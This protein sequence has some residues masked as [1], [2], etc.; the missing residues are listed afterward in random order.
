MRVQK[1]SSEM[2]QSAM[3][4]IS[5]DA[6]L[7]F[8]CDAM[9]RR[10]PLSTVRMGDGERMLIDYY[11]TGRHGRYSNDPVWLKEYGLWR[12]DLKQIGKSLL[13]AAQFADYMCP[14][15]SGLTLPK[16][17][18]LSILPPRDFY[19]EGLYAH[20]WL[21]MGRLPEIMNY[22]GGIAVVCRNSKEVSSRLFA[23]YKNKGMNSE[24]AE[25][26]SWQN[27]DGVLE[28]I[29][30]MKS[31]LILVSAG[32]SGKYLCVEAAKKYGKV[33]LDTGSALIRHWSVSKTRN[34]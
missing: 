15:I 10:T 8:V 6:L 4:Y 22:D 14:N 7:L 24:T 9:A 16:Y 12:A 29:G 27:Y 28:A 17:E 34:I 33:V 11:R 25:Y 13:D 23:K 21:Y 3:K 5:C 32:P 30:K 26:T 19:C 2:K 20:T 18:I 31:H 1:Y